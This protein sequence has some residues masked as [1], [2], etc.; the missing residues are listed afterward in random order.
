MLRFNLLPGEIVF[1][2]FGT[3]LPNP[4]AADKIHQR[5]LYRECIPVDSVPDFAWQ[6]KEG[7]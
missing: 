4:A 2:K 7:R 6:S 5:G 1:G 3:E